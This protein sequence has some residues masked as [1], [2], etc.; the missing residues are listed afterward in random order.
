MQ[1]DAFGCKHEGLEM[2][3]EWG[4]VVPPYVGLPLK[5]L[6]QDHQLGSAVDQLGLPV[7]VRNSPMVDWSQSDSVS[8]LGESRVCTTLEEVF[9]AADTLVLRDE[10]AA[11]VQRFVATAVS[12][13]A[14]VFGGDP[15]LSLAGVPLAGAVSWSTFPLQ[16]VSGSVPVAHF[17]IAADPDD[18]LVLPEVDLERLSDLPDELLERMGEVSR[19]VAERGGWFELEWL[20]GEEELWIVQLQPLDPTHAVWPYAEG[21]HGVD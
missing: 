2:A 1:R 9:R 17:L 10:L 11:V 5:G 12:G 3:V 6:R 7:I 21:T 16:A 8:G 20:W 18:G 15:V 19:A 14:Q 4:L 13:V